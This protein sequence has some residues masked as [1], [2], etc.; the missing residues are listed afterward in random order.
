[1]RK[2]TQKQKAKVQHNITHL[3]SYKQHIT[4]A[5][6]LAHKTVIKYQYTTSQ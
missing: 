2:F 4:S 6:V 3:L 1:M 5:E